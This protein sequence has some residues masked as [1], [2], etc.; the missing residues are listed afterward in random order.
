M[1]EF[2]VR[3]I[4]QKMIGVFDDDAF[5]YECVMDASKDEIERFISKCGMWQMQQ[6]EAL[7][8]K[9]DLTSLHNKK[10]LY[11]GDSIT[12][13]RFGYRGIT[14]LAAE[15]NSYNG[16]VSG[17]TSVD[18]LRF[19]SDNIR[20]SNPEIISLMIGTNDSLTI[21]D[22]KNLVSVQEYRNNISEILRI[23]KQFTD[24]II[25]STLPPVN[26][27]AYSGTHNTQ[28]SK[29]TVQS[30][31]ALCDVVKEEADI[32]N[33]YINDAYKALHDK[34]LDEIVE[35][36]GVHLTKE[37]QALFAEQWIKSV[38]GMYNQVKE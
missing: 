19:L 25:I 13:D 23:S 22:K 37:G 31:E 30:V 7:K 8:Q 16:A 6:A 4:L 2:F 12:A 33:V 11:I 15:L 18:M 29:M 17:A 36:D 3:F 14:T 26:E 27:Q 20:K 1:D 24:K 10:K 21:C 34:N 35:K 38:L 9:F 28:L 32:H 5:R